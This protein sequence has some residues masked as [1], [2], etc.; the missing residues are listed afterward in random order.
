MLSHLCSLSKNLLPVGIWGL[1]I[2]SLGFFSGALRNQ[3]PIPG[4]S[5]SIEDLGPMK[6]AEKNMPFPLL[7]CHP[8][9]AFLLP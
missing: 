3:T 4:I 5:E 7:S 8:L 9:L 6:L 1:H 2:P